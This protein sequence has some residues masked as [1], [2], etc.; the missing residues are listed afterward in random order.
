MGRGEKPGERGNV[1]LKSWTPQTHMGILLGQN[2]G[3]VYQLQKHTTG[4]RASGHAAISLTERWGQTGRGREVERSGG[5]GE[6][7]NRADNLNLLWLILLLLQSSLQSCQHLSQGFLSCC[8]AIGGRDDHSSS[9]SS[10]RHAACGPCAELVGSR[11]GSRPHSAFSN[12]NGTESQN[13]DGFGGCGLP[14]NQPR[15]MP[16]AKVAMQAR[17]KI[18]YFGEDVTLCTECSVPSTKT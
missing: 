11:L 9:G 1:E 18:A 6:D 15:E 2:N 7:T 16:A 13:G 8:P 12:N 3:S 5:R 14:L 4:G 10:G 17:Q